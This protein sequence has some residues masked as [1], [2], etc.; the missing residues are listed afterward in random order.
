[1]KKRTL[2]GEKYKFVIICRLALLRMGNALDN[3]CGE[4]KNTRF[5]TFSNSSSENIAIYGM[6]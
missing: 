2:L 5:I 3:T 4:N 1:M 6:E